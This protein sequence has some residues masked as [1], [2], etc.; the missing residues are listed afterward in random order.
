V[1]RTMQDYNLH[2]KPKKLAGD[3][4]EVT[5]VRY[6]RASNGRRVEGSNLIQLNLFDVAERMPNLERFGESPCL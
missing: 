1:K 6:Q 4:R 3:S 5:T 2:F